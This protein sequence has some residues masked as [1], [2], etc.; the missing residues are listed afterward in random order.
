M[1]SVHCIRLLLFVMAMLTLPVSFAQVSI[2]VNFAPPELPVY[3]QPPCP[4]EGYI[5]IPGYWG[6]DGDDYYWV[7][8]GLGSWLRKSACCGPRATGVGAAIALFSMKVTG[9]HM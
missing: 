6:W 9:V 3:D 5:W 1:H 8:L 2:S 7:P 4:D